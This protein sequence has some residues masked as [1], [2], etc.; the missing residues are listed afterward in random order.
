MQVP[1]RGQLTHAGADLVL[2]DHLRDLLG[3][4]PTLGLPLADALRRDSPPEH[5]R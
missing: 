2:T 4:Q 5:R 3:R 1:A